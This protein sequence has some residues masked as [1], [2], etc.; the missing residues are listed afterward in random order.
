MQFAREKTKSQQKV[1]CYATILNNN[2][3]KNDILIFLQN[4]FIKWR[5]NRG[6]FV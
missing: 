5:G 3:N 4:P 6:L 1:Q 2:D